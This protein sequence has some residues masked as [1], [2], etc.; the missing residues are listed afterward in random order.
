MQRLTPRGRADDILHGRTALE[1]Q[2]H[3][4]GAWQRRR[5]PEGRRA[6]VLRGDD[7][8]WEQRGVLS[9]A[10]SLFFKKKIHESNM[11]FMNMKKWKV[12]MP[13]FTIYQ[14]YFSHLNRTS[15][16]HSCGCISR[17][18]PAPNVSKSTHARLVAGRPSRR[19]TIRHSS[20]ID[21]NGECLYVCGV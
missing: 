2:L 12:T 13:M 5:V 10:R 7:Q 19:R 21:A 11:V 3:R 1:H 15:Q 20:C 9:H 17:S 4:T 18:M 16:T 8:S 14:T 6:M